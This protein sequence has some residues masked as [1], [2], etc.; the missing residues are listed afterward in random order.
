MLVDKCTSPHNLS[1][2]LL[3]ED[4]RRRRNKG[5]LRNMVGLT[6]L[7]V[8]PNGDPFW[9]RYITVGLHVRG[10][11]HYLCNEENSVKVTEVSKYRLEECS[12]LRHKYILGI[13]SRKFRKSRP[14]CKFN[15][16][17]IIFRQKHLVTSQ[18]SEK[19]GSKTY[20]N[21]REKVW[22]TSWNII[23]T[24]LQ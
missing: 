8:G 16:R 23:P 12:N 7:L 13:L 11:S 14:E 17:L 22:V 21:E 4:T 2:N 5:M 24:L 15:D 1:G 19:Q 10:V 18:V 6:C 20:R 9:R 3:K